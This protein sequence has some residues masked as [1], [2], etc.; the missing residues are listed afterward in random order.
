M[1]I[2]LIIGG[3]FLSLTGWSQ[4]DSIV[5]PSVKSRGGAIQGTTPQPP[6][7]A[8]VIDSTLVKTDSL[9]PADSMMH[10]DGL[11]HRFFTKGYPNPRKAALMSLVIPGS[12]Q[13][14]N[15]KWWKIPLVYGALGGLT[16]WEIESIKDYKLYKTNYKYKVDDDPLTV[17]TEPKLVLMDAVT[18][19]ANREIARKNLERSSLVLGLGY[20]LSVTD[21]FV[22]AH[23][24]TFDISDDLSLK[25]CPK[26]STIP[27]FGPTFGLGILVQL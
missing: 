19:K 20:L 9:A 25:I 24:A 7:V 5:P 6:V 21:A 14:Y 10:K 12:G 3:L 4:R 22:D 15:R 27:G 23:M 17:V 26:T 1:R 11:V 2:L 8:P 18:L 13:A 16:W